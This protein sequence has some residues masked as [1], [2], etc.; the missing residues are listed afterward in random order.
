[1]RDGQR[2]DALTAISLVKEWKKI[3]NYGFRLWRKLCNFVIQHS[4]FL[5]IQ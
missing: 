2:G 5:E 4:I 1:M 3:G